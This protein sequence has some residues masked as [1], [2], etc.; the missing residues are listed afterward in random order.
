MSK[1]MDTALDV[2]TSISHGRELNREAVG[3][4][5]GW[6]LNPQNEKSPD[7]PRVSARVHEHFQHVAGTA[8]AASLDAHG[9]IVYGKGDSTQS[10]AGALAG[11]MLAAS[12]GLPKGTA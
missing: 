9:L 2:A 7:F 12:S 5:Q 1:M 6:M 11:R 3:L 8:P 10:A 4:L